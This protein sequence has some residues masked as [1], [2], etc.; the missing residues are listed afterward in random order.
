[1]PDKKE[2]PMDT[3]SFAKNVVK[4]FT[5]GS[6]FDPDMTENEANRNPEFTTKEV[7]DHITGKE[8][9]SA[10]ELEELKKATKYVNFL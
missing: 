3:K 8:K 1:M 4:G 7:I 10:K 2:Q 5:I 6:V 9:L